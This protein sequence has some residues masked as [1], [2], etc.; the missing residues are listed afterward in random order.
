MLITPSCSRG[1][2]GAAGYSH[3]GRTLVPLIPVA[4]LVDRGVVKET[5]LTELRRFDHLIN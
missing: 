2:Q 1:A 4:E 5:T 3:P